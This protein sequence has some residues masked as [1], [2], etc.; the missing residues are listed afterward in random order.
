MP[1]IQVSRSPLEA[2]WERSILFNRELGKDPLGRAISFRG[3]SPAAM[4]TLLEHNTPVEWT[5]ITGSHGIM[6][7]LFFID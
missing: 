4:T 7:V 3:M 2:L 6:E 1:N 5:G